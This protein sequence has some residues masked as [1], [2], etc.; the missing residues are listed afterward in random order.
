MDLTIIGGCFALVVLLANASA[1][2]SAAWF[3]DL[4]DNVRQAIT[5]RMN[6]LLTPNSGAIVTSS[7]DAEIPEPVILP[8]TGWDKWC[9]KFPLLLCKLLL[10]PFCLRYHLVFW[11]AVLCVLPYLVASHNGWGVGSLLFLLPVVWLSAV[12]LSV[13]LPSFNRV[14]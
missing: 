6:S 9:R 5:T 3:G 10:C 2:A 1:A 11:L 14:N 12:W 13:R 7:P 4:F 8:A